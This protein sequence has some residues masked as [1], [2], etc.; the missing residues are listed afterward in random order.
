MGLIT[1]TKTYYTD[2]TGYIYE[3]LVGKV[4]HGD[5]TQTIYWK[6][7]RCGGEMSYKKNNDYA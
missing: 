2:S 3:D 7:T 5:D 4:T 1:E 6:N